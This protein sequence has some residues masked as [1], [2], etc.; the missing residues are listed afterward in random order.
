MKGSKKRSHIILIA[1]LLVF[2]S[3][4][5][6]SAAR[7]MKTDTISAGVS[8]G[9]VRLG[10]LTEEEASEKLRQVLHQTSFETPI[11]LSFGDIEKTVVPAE[12]LAAYDYAETAKAARAY[13]HEGAFFR[14]I[15]QAAR[16]LL[17][18]KSIPMEISYDEA[19]YDEILGSLMGGLREKVQDHTWEIEGENLVVTTG[20]P[21]LMP[22]E[23]AVSE[24]ILN[25]IRFASYEDKI[26][27]KKESRNPAPLTADFLSENVCSE[28]KNASYVIENGK[29]I[30]HPHV[31]GI[32]FDK[33]EAQAIIDGHTGYG[34]Q[35]VIPLRIQEPD[36]LLSDIEEKLFSEVIGE[37]STKFNAGDVSRSKN[38]AL[39]SNKI[40]GTILAPNEIFSYNDVVG[41]R[42]YSEGFE[43]AG[44]Y[45][46]G[47]TVQGLGGGI[48][49]VSSTLFNAVVLANLDI[50]ERVNHQLTVSYVP[51]GR[52]AT[53][54]Y[55]NIDFRFKNTT[56]Y[57]IKIT[58]TADGG[59]MYVGINGYKEDKDV[60]VS[61][62]TVTI[63][64]TPPPERKVDDP[65][66]P[67]G[68]EKVE[69]DGTSGYIVDTYKVITRN[70]EEPEKIYLCR[71]SYNG[72]FRIIHV[73]TGEEVPSPS[74]TEN[75]DPA[76]T[77]KPTDTEIPTPTSSIPTPTSSIPTPQ[78]SEEAKPTPSPD[79]SPSE[80]PE[81]ISDT[82]L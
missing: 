12:F 17:I 48:C 53:V 7:A 51:L 15:A 60:M 45:V 6:V 21:G 10:G 80:S 25:T 49:Q 68:E 42:S 67:K 35:F 73:G 26:I 44:V 59:K 72:N 31:L 46:N 38:I 64:H 27:F 19:A 16:T 23:N 33:T 5:G 69:K 81:R 22:D 76:E 58:C 1:V 74:P 3:A 43:T 20:R 28:A 62:E 55:G 9:G 57:P 40:N 79:L 29:V 78:P 56:G 14:R 32:S 2:V 8:A 47:E 77:E 37:Y 24:S 70:G 50:V 65:T 13:C 63:G 66:L 18:P 4:L 52:D 82:G 30:L 39:A 54:D 61:F 75:V 11:H 71:S 34:I 41:E 36:V